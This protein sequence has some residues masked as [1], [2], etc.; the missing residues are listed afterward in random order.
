MSRL[1]VNSRRLI[2]GYGL[3]DSNQPQR[4]KTDLVDG[5]PGGLSSLK[6]NEA[7][8]IRYRSLLELQDCRTS[9]SAVSWDSKSNLCNTENS[10][11]EHCSALARP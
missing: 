8:F 1:S 6:E 11:K 3:V 4:T 7:I 2:R 5:L 10:P 9:G